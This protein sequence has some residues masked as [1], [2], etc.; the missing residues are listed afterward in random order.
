MKL[1]FAQACAPFL[2]VCVAACGSPANVAGSYAVNLTN[3]DNGCQFDNWTVGSMT[4]NVLISITQSSGDATATVTGVAG[5]YLAVIL[6]SAAFTGT[7]D[8]NS[9]TLKL[10]GT[11]S[12]TKGSCSYTINAVIR[13]A[14]NGDLIEGTI[15][16]ESATNGSPD[17]ATIE[18]CAS[19]QAFNGTRPPQ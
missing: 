9:L 7:V 17:C 4:S 19:A 10:F 13:A 11:R 5:A 16:Y 18:G 14:S 12:A 15:S 6:G 1:G 3:K 8:G 2:L